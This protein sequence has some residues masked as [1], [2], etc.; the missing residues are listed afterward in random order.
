MFCGEPAE[1]GCPE[2]KAETTCIR[3]QVWH[4]IENDVIRKLSTVQVVLE[5]KKLGRGNMGG[6]EMF[7]KIKA[8]VEG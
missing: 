8:K 6:D 2:V 3:W 1:L 4:P 5:G 7:K